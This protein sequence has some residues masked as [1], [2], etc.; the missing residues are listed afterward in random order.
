[1]LIDNVTES[2]NNLADQAALSADRAIRSTQR[3]ANQAL[4]GLTG[5][6]QDLRQ[7]AAP[8]LNRATEQASALA[9]RGVDVVRE[10]SRQVRDQAL[11]ASDGTLHYVRQEPVK[12]MLIA[13]AVGATLMVLLSRWGGLRERR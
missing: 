8:L 13:A 9:Q 10:G 6:V 4:D 2:H 12:S 11:R 3:M 1:M 7:Q 5:S